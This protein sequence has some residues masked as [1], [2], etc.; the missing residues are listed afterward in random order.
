MRITKELNT[1][2]KIPKS[3]SGITLIAIV[4]TII[5]MLILV[6]VTIT[7]AVNGGLFDYARR[8]GQETNRAIA[9]EQQLG[10][11]TIIEQHLYGISEE[12]AK[13]PEYSESLLDE[14][15]GVLTINAKYIDDNKQVA[16][17]PKG[18]KL[19]SEI[20]DEIDEGIVITDKVDSN[21]NSTGN[22][23]VW[24]PVAKG[25]FERT[26]WENNE[27]TGSVSSSFV[28]NAESDPT[29]EYTNMVNSVNLY[30]G[31]YIG[32][33]EA[34][35][36]NKEGEPVQR[37]NTANETSELVVKAGQYPYNF[38]GWGPSANGYIGEITYNSLNQGYGAVYKSK[39]MY[40]DKEIYGVKS[41]LCYGVQ[42]D[43]TLKFIKDKVD[44]TNSTAWGNYY[45]S[46]F[47]FTGNYYSNSTW[48]STTTTKKGVGRWLLTTGASEQNKA[49]NIY[50]LAGNV[51]EWT[52]E[53]YPPVNR[54]TRGGNCSSY[55][56]V[57]KYDASIRTTRDP[58]YCDYTIGF[59]PTLY[60]AS[61]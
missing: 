45:G 35:A 10:T 21:G 32:R 24:V 47:S 5:V 12:V 44:V 22:E 48:S 3:N 27:P 57:G 36:Q 9:A 37:T 34:G 43:A 26:Q 39:N 11:G 23:F 58:K 15:T 49:K 29:G 14:D 16:V 51:E 7:M 20:E 30:G 2:N 40:T 50:D 25:T 4:I 53:Y 33:Y 1:K 18:F 56:A 59:R 55:S 46:T 61:E 38:V 8:A 42:W 41:T 31:F 60:M 13:L 6:A 54:V 28:Q 19:L 17:I 52:I